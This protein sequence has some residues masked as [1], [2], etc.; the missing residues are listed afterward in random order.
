M[1]LS[2]RQKIIFLVLALLFFVTT[3]GALFSTFEIQRYYR[4]LVYRQ[5]AV[6]LN[7]I[8]YL[9]GSL[10]PNL[11]EAERDSLLFKLSSIS[12]QRLTLID[13]SGIVRFDSA[14]PHDSLFLLENH[15]NR[16]EIR[17]A[18]REGYGHDERRSASVHR[19][20]FYAAK[21]VNNPSLLP[22]RYIRLA[23]PAE[24]VH[25]VLRAFRW[26]IFGGSGAAFCLIAFI[27]YVAAGRI[28]LPIRHLSQVATAVKQGNRQARFAKIHD[29]ELGALASL[30]NQMLDKLQE[31]FEKMKRL[32]R[33]RS[34]FLGNVSHELRT[35]I[36][37]IQGYLETLLNNPDIDPRK[38]QEFIAKT[39]HQAMRLNSLLTDLI[40]ISRIESGEMKM[41]FSPFDVY[42][43]LQKIT[44]DFQETALKH[45]INLQSAWPENKQ[46]LV[47]G[48][49]ERLT[50]A[51]QNLVTNAI[52]YNFPGGW[53]RVGF[54]EHKSRVEIFVEDSGRGIAEEHIPRIFERFYRVDKERSR[55]MGG[56]GLGLAIVKHI[57]EAHGSKVSVESE[58]GKGSRFSFQLKKYVQSSDHES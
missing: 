20:M 14:V 34:Q 58:L 35:P 5:L 50:Q 57:V 47:L 54:I 23:M 29:D 6:K 21:A 28:T 10:P 26:K 17:A 52:K 39:Y 2:L 4:R 30:L 56:T 3:A 19:P 38:R 33:V 15:I 11:T 44:A 18:A 24:N 32:E 27:S 51:M 22:V 36:F 42:E 37:S 9:M 46:V 45:S 43:W 48:D 7:E 53:V 16:P 1:H 31:D 12:G 41:S 49:R 55:D 40:D 25:A 8:E 13:S